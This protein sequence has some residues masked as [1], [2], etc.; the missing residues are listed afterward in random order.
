MDF[1][2]RYDAKLSV[3]FCTVSG[4]ADPEELLAFFG[5]VFDDPDIP[6]NTDAIWDLRYLDFSTASPEKIKQMAEIRV[7]VHPQRAGSRYAFVVSSESQEA[8]VRLF[9][10]HSRE[11]D[12]EKAVFR[13]M[14]DAMNWMT[15]S[16]GQGDQPP[17][18]RGA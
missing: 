17:A 2:T 9:W 5:R 7:S 12:Q 18:S 14:E 11:I 1:A 8:L 16:N 6:D 15:G 13:T 3:L 4:T 10:A